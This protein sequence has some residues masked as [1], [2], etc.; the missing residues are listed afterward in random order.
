MGCVGAAAMTPDSIL[1][2]LAILFFLVAL[3]GSNAKLN[4]TA[5]GGLCL[6]VYH[7]LGLGLFA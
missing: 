6:A 7:L 2:F 4:W 3:F 1:I 5:A